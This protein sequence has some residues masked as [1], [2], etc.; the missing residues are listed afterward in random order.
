MGREGIDVDTIQEVLGRTAG[1]LFEIA[2]ELRELCAPGASGRKRGEHPGQPE[3]VR[4]IKSFWEGVRLPPV[5]DAGPVRIDL[6]EPQGRWEL[7]V[8]A[9]LRAARVREEIAARTF[10]ALKDESLLDLRLLAKGEA[11]TRRR[12]ER[13][14]DR[15]YK[16]LGSRQAKAEAIVENARLLVNEWGGDLA[17]LYDAGAGDEE[18]L[19]R[20][21]RFRQINRVALWICR[22]LRA[23]GIWQGIGPQASRFLDRTVSTP[24]ARLRLGSLPGEGEEGLQRVDLR[25]L[26]DATESVVESHFGGDVIWLYSHGYSLCLQ[27]DPNVC[28][29]ECPVSPWCTFPRG[30]EE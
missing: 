12:V 11:E 22:T 23:H 17:R 8:L 15:H 6:S 18:L 2:S 9:M 19:R 26:A 1:A 13:V 27:N 29:A 3:V 20:L 21:Q 24:V 5:F 7:L 10:Q 16:A 4:R 14:L 30:E 28:Y 25:R